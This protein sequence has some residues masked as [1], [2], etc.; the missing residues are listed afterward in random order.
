[1]GLHEPKNIKKYLGRAPGFATPA[2]DFV[3][4]ADGRRITVIN[5]TS[6]SIER[7]LSFT[8]DTFDAA[9]A[10]LQASRIVTT[11]HSRYVFGDRFVRFVMA[12]D[13]GKVPHRKSDTHELRRK[14][15]VD[16]ALTDKVIAAARAGKTITR[17]AVEAVIPSIAKKKDPSQQKTGWA[18]FNESRAFRHYARDLVLAAIIDGVK[19][20][21]AVYTYFRGQLKNALDT[22]T[23]DPCIGEADVKIGHIMCCADFADDHIIL[24]SR[25]SDWVAIWLLVAS[26]A[27][28]PTTSRSVFWCDDGMYYALDKIRECWPNAPALAIALMQAKTDFVLNSSLKGDGPALDATYSLAAPIVNLTRADLDRITCNAH[29]KLPHKSQAPLAST[30]DSLWWNLHYWRIC[31]EPTEEQ[32]SRALNDN[33]IG[34]NTTHN[35]GGVLPVRPDPQAKNHAEEERDAAH[36][37]GH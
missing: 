30:T 28:Y 15:D 21:T 5:D 18:Q 27:A 19:G 6:G 1:M 37:A 14:N 31:K 9:E 12:T 23:V 35:G 3:P 25:D 4:P 17:E 10:A 34:T 2:A 16:T 33:R 22:V 36:P 32:L 26:S 13:D 8:S 11:L 20:E 24:D 7:I 29:R